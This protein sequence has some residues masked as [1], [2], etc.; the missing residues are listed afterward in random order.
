MSQQFQK[1]S[2]A[3]KLYAEHIA[4]IKK[5]SEL[6]QA[7]VTAFLDA[8]RD[9]VQS[10]LPQAKVEEK[11]TKTC[12]EWWIKDADAKNHEDVPHIFILTQEPEIV[13][14]GILGLKVYANG[15]LT[16]YHQRLKEMISEIQLPKSREN[17]MLA[18]GQVLAVDVCYGQSDD[19]V[20]I[21]AEPVRILLLAL[22]EAGKKLRTQI[23][24][25]T[26]RRV[27]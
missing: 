21:A 4:V 14:P 1:F 16:P 15:I 25:S 12:R 10:Q 8:L 3:A 18:G 27:S 5:M 2:D 9:R 20:S 22:D 11:I 17:A 6:F 13:V 19:P 23:S 24:K 26:K 7:D